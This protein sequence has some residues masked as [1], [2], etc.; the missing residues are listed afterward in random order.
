MSHSFSTPAVEV[1]ATLGAS[2]VGV[3]HGSDPRGGKTRPATRALIAGGAIGVIAGVLAFIAATRVAA[4]NQA[5][6]EA[7]VASGRPAWAFRPEEVSTWLSLL[8]FAG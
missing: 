2:I 4:G 8:S 6:L 1:V 5:G 3:R 7:W